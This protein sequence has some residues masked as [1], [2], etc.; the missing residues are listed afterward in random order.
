MK[1]GTPAVRIAVTPASVRPRAAFSAYCTV[2]SATVAE[3]TRGHSRCTWTSQRPGRRCAPSRSTTSAPLG[4]GPPRSDT[5]V[6]RPLSI[7]TLA[8]RITP[9][10]TQ[11]ISAALVRTSAIERRDLPAPG[12]ARSGG[13]HRV[14]ERGP[15]RHVLVV[16]PRE[17]DRVVAEHDRRVPRRVRRRAAALEAFDD[18]VVVRIA[19]EGDR[20]AI[21]GRPV[22]HPVRRG[23]EA[24]VGPSMQDVAAVDHERAEV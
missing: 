21:A 3:G 24:L 18:R 11:S 10:R 12:R 9:G 2:S 7:W 14:V 8:P 22:D 4:T 17:P 5:A 13:D 6:M 16:L 15:L 23:E 19:E 1:W 20:V